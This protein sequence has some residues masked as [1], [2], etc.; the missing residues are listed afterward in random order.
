MPL[1]ND[2]NTKCPK[3]NK[4]VALTN[5]ILQIYKIYTNKNTKKLFSMSRYKK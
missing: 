2:G 3:A 4:L 5:T 1:F